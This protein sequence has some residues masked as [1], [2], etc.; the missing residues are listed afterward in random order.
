MKLLMLRNY[1]I[2]NKSC[3]L[4]FV[5]KHFGVNATFAK[6]MLNLL[7]QKKLVSVVSDQN[8]CGSKCV[9]CTPDFNTR[10]EWI[11]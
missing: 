1:L 9:K 3:T 5:I 2:E 7:Q 6:E 11:G 4:F 10:Y 8:L